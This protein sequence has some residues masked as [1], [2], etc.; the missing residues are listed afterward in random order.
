MEQDV[1]IS[2]SEIS[3]RG[4]FAN[5]DFKKG[6][7]IIKWN[8][9]ILTKNQFQKLP[10]EE[11]HFVYELA[12]KYLYM[13]PPEKYMNHSCE[14]NTT[15]KNLSDIAVHDIKKGEEITADYSNDGVISFDCNCGTKICKGT[16]S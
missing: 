15:A 16:V 5:R 6:E 7:I 2:R 14:S 1:I 11:K 4:L 3:G 8:P 9:K 12:G 10:D 13:Q